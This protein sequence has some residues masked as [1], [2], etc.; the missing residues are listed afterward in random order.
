MTWKVLSMRC[1]CLMLREGWECAKCDRGGWF[2]S[3]HLQSEY[4]PEADY[5][6]GCG[7]CSV[8]FPAIHRTRGMSSA[9]KPSSNSW[10]IGTRGRDR[11]WHVRCGQGQAGYQIPILPDPEKLDKDILLPTLSPVLARKKTLAERSKRWMVLS[12]MRRSSLQST[13]EVA[14]TS[15]MKAMT[16]SLAKEVDRTYTMPEIST[17]QEAFSYYAKRIARKVKLLPVRRLVPR[18][19]N[20][21]ASVLLVHGWI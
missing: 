4:P 17:S 12:S 18:Y 3:L 15:N 1:Q 5:G 13:D 11:L 20:F 6:R 7:S 14:K 8:N 16:C 21:S 9:T 19:R 2:A 10:K